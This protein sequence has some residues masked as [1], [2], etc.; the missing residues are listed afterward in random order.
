MDTARSIVYEHTPELHTEIVRVEEGC[1][2]ISAENVIAIRTQPDFRR[3]AM[4]GYAICRRDFEEMIASSEVRNVS[5]RVLAVINAG[6]TTPYHIEKNCA[7]RILTGAPVPDGA[8]WIVRQ[9]DT[10]YGE[11]TVEIFD[12]GRFDN[13]CVAG[14]DFQ[15]G[16]ILI[17]KGE[18]MDSFSLASAEAAGITEISVFRKPKIAI[19]SSGNELSEHPEKPGEIYDSNGV[20]LRTRVAAL[21]CEPVLYR[22]VPDDLEHI[23]T[24]IQEGVDKAD[25]VITTDGVSVGNKDLLERALRECGAEIIF[26]GIRIKPG[27]P[28]MFSVLDKTPVLSLSGNPFSASCIF[29]YLFPY[30]HML[31]VKVPIA[32]E[33]KKKRPIPRIVRGLIENGSVFPDKISRNGSTASRI[34]RKGQPEI[35]HLRAN[36][37]IALPEGNVPI[38]EGD[39]VQVYIL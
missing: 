1:F 15:F 27:M 23:A 14:E 18:E 12:I 3:S 9:E 5:F 2:R 26:H 21:N 29:E 16:D 38:R 10:N 17:R 25:F 11:E 13:I 39:E 37:L 6:D 4:N 19:I 28:S 20:Y 24:V 32:E 8:D 7:F 35:K 36:C 34:G 22:R 31:S 33:Y 30:H